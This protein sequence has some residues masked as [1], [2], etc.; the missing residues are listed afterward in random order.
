V[1]FSGV[2]WTR[3]GKGILLQPLRRAEKRHAQRH[4]LFSKVYYHKLGTPQTE[5]VLVY[6]RPDQKDW[7][8]GGTVTE[9]GNYLIITSTRALT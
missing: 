8:F 1:K 2:S 9:D 5:D 6:E 4:E 7:L 3:D